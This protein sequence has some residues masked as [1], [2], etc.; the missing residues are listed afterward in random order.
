MRISTSTSSSPINEVM[1]IQSLL[2]PLTLASFLEDYYDKKPLHIQ[3]TPSKAAQVMSWEALETLLGMTSIWSSKSLQLVK[4]HQVIPFQEYCIQALDR[5]NNQV[6]MPLPQKVNAI[7][8]GGATLVANDMDQLTPGMKACAAAL[9]ETFLGK[10]QANL[11]CSSEKI[12]GFASHFDTHDVF[13]LHV[14]GH[15][16]W[17]I[18]EGRAEEPIAHPK[19]KNFGQAHHEAAKGKI[20][21]EITLKPGDLLYIPRGQ[22]HDALADSKGT[23]HVSFGLTPMIGLDVI[24]QIFGAA[25]EDPLFR[26]RLPHGNTP[27]FDD[28]LKALSKNLSGI[29]QSGEFATVLKHFQKNYRY[30]RDAVYLT[31]QKG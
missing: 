22:Y 28:H 26:K 2:A 23:L 20:L 25:L 31:A 24:S 17:R 15:K 16:T 9:E 13:A 29:L 6:W 30:P 3:N 7:L 19:F 14:A 27:A 18:Y 21:M 11:Y 1:D 12:P 5:T 8:E 4:N 10:V